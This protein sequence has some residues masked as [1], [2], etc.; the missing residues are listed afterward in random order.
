MRIKSWIRKKFPN[1]GAAH[2]QFPAQVRPQNGERNV[3]GIQIRCH[4]PQRQDCRR[5]HRGNLRAVYIEQNRRR[6]IFA[7][8]QLPHGSRARKIE[9]ERCMFETG[10][11]Q[12]H[13]V[14]TGIIEENCRRRVQDLKYCK[15]LR[16][17]TK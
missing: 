6:S 1:E 7:L 2:P 11:Q 14:K 16:P 10:R 3:A 9:E 4:D 5:H 13:L 17:A 15:S 8:E 12:V